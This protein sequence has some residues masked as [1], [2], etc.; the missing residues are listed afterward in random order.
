MIEK[1]LF[2]VIFYVFILLLLAWILYGMFNILIEP[3][4]PE[5]VKYYG[6]IMRRKVES[7]LGGVI[8]PIRSFFWGVMA[9][10]GVWF[11]FIV[12][13]L[14]YSDRKLKEYFGDVEGV[15][16]TA[17]LPVP[18]EILVSVTCISFLA[19][20]LMYY[21]ESKSTAQTEVL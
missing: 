5:R 8:R 11:W 13:W 21:R 19:F 15:S 18:Y 9:A 6:E 14:I 20:V 7:K 17:W 1:I 10:L 3:L 4:L 16:F 12:A 2:G